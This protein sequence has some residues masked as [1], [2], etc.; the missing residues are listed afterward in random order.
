GE[1]NGG[2]LHRIGTISH[3]QDHLHP[4]HLHR[5]QRTLPHRNR[6]PRRTTH[7]HRT[8]TH[9]RTRLLATPGTHRRRPLP[10]RT[11][12]THDRHDRRLSTQHRRTR[13][14]RPGRPLHRHQGPRP[15]RNPAGTR[16]R[17][18]RKT[19]RTPPRHR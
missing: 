8:P 7:L 19:T 2:Q 15:P 13:T 18:H 6:P 9:L 16:R 14:L 4:A 11:P 5:G 3:Q 12:P 10:G 1:S 17:L